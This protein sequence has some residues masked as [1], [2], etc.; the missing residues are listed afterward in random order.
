MKKIINW[1]LFATLF[2]GLTIQTSC[3]SDHDGD[4]VNEEVQK[5]RDE[6]LTHIEDDAQVMDE[7]LDFEL[8][9][10][11]TQ[12]QAQL[13]DLMGRDPRFSGNLKKVVSV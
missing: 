10:L 11:T 12:V 2:L 5:E 7:N 9:D 4:S 13:L 8:L 6:L 3:S 1:V